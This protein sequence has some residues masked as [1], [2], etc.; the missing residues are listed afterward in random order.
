M[1]RFHL[2]SPALVI[3]MLALALVLGGTA[4]AASTSGD[5]KADTALVKKLAPSLSVKQ[6]AGLSVLPSGKSE[7]GVFSAGADNGTANS[8][9][10]GYGL[11][12]SR[13]LATAIK[14]SHIIDN[15]GKPPFTSDA[16]CPGFGHAAPGYLCLYDTVANSVS[17]GYGYSNNS[18]DLQQSPSIGVIIYWEE[19]GTDAYSGGE[20]TVTAP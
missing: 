8:D 20:W 14:N 6:A 4:V 12:Y 5:T 15:Q 7:S 2:P 17:P 16:H 10:L 19:N 13:P 9:Y 1:F 11:T 18:A 3:S